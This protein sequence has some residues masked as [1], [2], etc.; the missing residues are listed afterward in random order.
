MSQMLDRL[1]QG[2][3]SKEFPRVGAG[4]HT[5]AIGGFSLVK[6]KTET[7]LPAELL[8]I[9]LVAL[10]STAHKPGARVTQPFFIG[11]PDKFAGQSEQEVGRA[12]TFVKHACGLD[13]LEETQAQMEAI[14]KAMRPV[15]ANTSTSDSLF[16]IRIEC[17]AT[18]QTAKKSGKTFIESTWSHVDGQTADVINTQAKELREFL[19][20]KAPA[21][22]LSALQ[23]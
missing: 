18:L 10:E 22:G 20:I 2:Q 6:S 1:K 4:K 23:K 8:Q 19:G 21:A 7:G 12:L 9:E 14:F 3:F 13:S 16:G 15:D 5:F 11:F 17:V